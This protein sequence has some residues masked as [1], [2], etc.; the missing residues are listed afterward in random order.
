ML[1]IIQTDELLTSELT[2]GEGIN[3]MSSYIYIQLY[4][5][6][7]AQTWMNNFMEKNQ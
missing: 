2:R 3:L 1:N 6:I 5:V 4:Q 7:F